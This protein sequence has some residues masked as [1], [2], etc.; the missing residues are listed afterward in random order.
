MPA[1][2]YDTPLRR[3]GHYGL[4]AF[5]ILVFAFLVAP[6][7]IIIPLSFN[8]EPYFS[9]PMSGFSLR[10]YEE[11]FGS[12]RWHEAFANSFIIGIPAT[13]LATLLGTFA[14]LGLSRREF[15]LKGLVM[16]ILI[17]PM[18]VPIVITAVGMYFFYARIGLT[19]SYLGLIL[20]HTALA[21]PY[22]VITVTATLAGFD[23]GLVRAGASLGAGPLRVLRSITLPLILPGVISGALFAFATSFDEVVVVLF[24]GGV[25]QRTLPR[26][27]WSGIREAMTPTILAVATLLI[28]FALALMAVIELLRAR[29]ERL[30]GAHHPAPS[31]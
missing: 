26:Q 28:L 16:G 13:V 4:W 30:R 17:S 14:A 19:D 22:V 25:D 2:P 3:A 18:I 31:A 12:T 7:L 27:M 21:T 20:A 8:S 10:W 6:N 29:S 1:G 5:G 24:V 9:Y 23:T 11:L 15:P